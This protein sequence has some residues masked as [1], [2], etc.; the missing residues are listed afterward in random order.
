MPKPHTSPFIFDEARCISISELKKWKYL[1]KDSIK[2]G[3][4]NWKNRYDEITSSLPIRLVF[5]ENEQYLNLKYK[6][7]GNDYDYD[8]QLISTPSNI[9]NGL[10]WY[11]LCPFT[12][13][14]CRKLHLINERFMHRS[15]LPSGVYSKQ[16]HT[17]KWR[18]LEKIYGCYFDLDKYYKKLYSKNFKKYYNGK[19][20]KKYLALMT[21]I[22]KGERFSLSEIERLYAI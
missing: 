18:N 16:I 7:N 21:K 22:N 10:I 5:T 17:K 9:G 4:I 19:P 12:G 14:R 6:C 11:F 13:K 3:T 8:I 1:E 2:S 20:T 15:A